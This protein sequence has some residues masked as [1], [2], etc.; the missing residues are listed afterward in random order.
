M[1]SRTRSGLYSHVAEIMINALSNRAAP[2]LSIPFQKRGCYSVSD[3]QFSAYRQAAFT[4]AKA[5]L[6]FP[7]ALSLVFRIDAL[8]IQAFDHAH[9]KSTNRPPTR[10][11]QFA[12]KGRG[13]RELQS[14]SL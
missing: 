1:R 4:V 11:S 9:R 7:I 12:M 13:I 5:F 6:T 8:V 10:R 3:G 14:D 2:S